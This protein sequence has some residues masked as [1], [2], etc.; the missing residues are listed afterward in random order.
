EAEAWEDDSTIITPAKLANA[1]KNINN[2]LPIGALAFVPPNSPGWIDLAYDNVHGVP[3]ETYPALVAAKYCG[4]TNNSTAGWYYRAD[5][6]DGTVRNPAGAYFIL[7]GLKEYFIRTGVADYIL[8]QDQIKAHTHNL[9][10]NTSVQNGA[11]YNSVLI[12]KGVGDPVGNN[13]IAA[14]GDSETTPKY[15]YENVAIKAYDTATNAESIDVAYVINAIQR[16]IAGA[17][18]AGAPSSRFID[19]ALPPN[20]G[21][22][23][24]PAD[25]WVV[26]SKG[27]TAIGQY[28]TLSIF[29]TQF[30]GHNS[31]G[32]VMALVMSQYVKK[33]TV[34][35]FLYS[36]AGKTNTCR[37]HF[38][39]DNETA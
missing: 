20:G 6:M 27:A 39:T 18:G 31:P 24:A 30:V 19:I 23:T 17:S 4:D 38:S 12:Q 5:D 33:G 13:G 10:G 14:F 3:V 35:T 9:N 26:V 32:A 37:F 1:L 7:P 21:T 2:G 16:L 36:A 29:G 28:L 22:Y 11:P 8:H 15:V 25:G 34:I